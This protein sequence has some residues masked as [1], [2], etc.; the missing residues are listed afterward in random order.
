MTIVKTLSWRCC[1]GH[2]QL[3]SLFVLEV[4]T[5]Y[6]NHRER[7]TGKMPSS[8]HFFFSPAT[9]LSAA[10]GGE[11]SCGARNPC[12]GVVASRTWWMVSCS[13]WFISWHTW[14]LEPEWQTAQHTSWHY[15]IVWPPSGV[16][17]VIPTRKLRHHYHKVQQRII[18]DI[19]TNN[20][21]IGGINQCCGPRFCAPTMD[22]CI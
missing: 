21:L 17:T 10:C 16:L 5:V 6:V 13:I 2:F 22:S 8:S 19:K 3:A 18:N 20:N 4:C 9:F 11:K 14:Q 12:C 15:G 1:G 7:Y